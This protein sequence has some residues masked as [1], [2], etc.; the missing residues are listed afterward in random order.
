MMK[1]YE[2]ITERSEADG[3]HRM[4]QCI[5]AN[6]VFQVAINFHAECLE[7]D[8]E[9]IS[10]S[11]VCTIVQT[12][13]DE[14]QGMDYEAVVNEIE[15]FFSG[16]YFHVGKIVGLERVKGEEQDA[17]GIFDR[18]YVD[19]GGGGIAG[20]DFHGTAYFHIGDAKFASVEY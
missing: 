3:V 4:R 15:Q 13:K 8:Q 10:I 17:F 6:S 1:V 5:Q 16:E 7:T 12:L 9:I 11:Y 14:G 19:Q 2:L 18:V 20:D